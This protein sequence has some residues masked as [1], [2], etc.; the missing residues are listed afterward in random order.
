MANLSEKKITDLIHQLE[1]DYQQESTMPASEIKQLFRPLKENCEEQTGT[2]YHEAEYQPNP[3]YLLNFD[4]K[5]STTAL[6]DHFLSWNEKA[7]PHQMI[8]FSFLHPL[9]WKTDSL[10]SS[11]SKSSLATL[12]ELLHQSYR[13]DFKLDFRD[14]KPF[15]DKI[16]KTNKTFE[17][18]YTEKTVHS[19]FYHLKNRAIQTSLLKEIFASPKTL[20]IEF[21]NYCK[22]RITDWNH[23][24]KKNIQKELKR[25]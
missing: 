13:F 8:I 9:A 12:T 24:T 20:E 22:A 11:H 14:Q 7:S 10:Y 16:L 2:I 25:Q 19:Q 17:E 18:I 23:K 6:L 21:G 1:R 5:V 3:L 15:S 4:R